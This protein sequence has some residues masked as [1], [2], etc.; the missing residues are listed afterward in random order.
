[1][2]DVDAVDVVAVVVDEDGERSEFNGQMV[3]LIHRFQ[4]E[5]FVHV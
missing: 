2:F 5:Y 3:S 4:R 1:L